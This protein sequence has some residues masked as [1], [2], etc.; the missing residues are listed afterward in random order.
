MERHV[1]LLI[2]SACV[3]FATQVYEAATLS[4]RPTP[5][6]RRN[7]LKLFGKTNSKPTRIKVKVQQDLKTSPWGY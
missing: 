6:V 5:C 1:L 3:E 4:P 2:A 7:V